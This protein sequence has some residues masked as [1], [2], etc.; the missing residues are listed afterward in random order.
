MPRA[1][2]PGQVFN[3]ASANTF[4]LGWLA[5]R[6]TGTA[7]ADLLGELLWRRIG[8]EGDALL[9]I[10]RHGATAVH[11][12]LLARLRDVARFG[13]LFTPSWPVVASEP[14]VS[15][16]YL[17]AIQHGGRPELFA[18]SP[19]GQASIELYQPPRPPHN[20]YQWDFVVPGG[21]FFKGGYGGQVLLIE[22][23]RDLVVAAFGSYGEDGAES[24]MRYVAYQLAV[25]GLFG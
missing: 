15:E 8:A 5:E 13:L 23:A 6:V 9:S 22:P 1:Q 18:R 3:Y 21:P 12:G 19:R 2:E 17:H 24:D 25:S 20:T 7:Y 10:S 16:R 14:L 4:V 11:G